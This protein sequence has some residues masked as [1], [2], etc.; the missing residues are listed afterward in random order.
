M[1]PELKP[2]SGHTHSLAK[3]RRYFEGKEGERVLAKDFLNLC[4]V[5]ARG[6]TWD[7]QMDELR[8]LSGNNTDS[9][10]G[11]QTMTY[12]HYIISPDSRDDVTLEQLRE[13]ATSWARRF[14]GDYQ[15]AIIYH[16]DNE[17]G[18]RHAHVIV[19]N[20][21]LTDGH[22]LSSDLTNR[23]VKLLNNALQT[24]ALERGLSAFAEDHSSMNEPEM[25]SSGKNVSRDGGDPMWRAHS[26]PGRSRSVASMPR[27]SRDRRERRRDKSQRG[28]DERGGRSWKGEICDCVDVARRLSANQDDFR[29]VLSAMG[30]RLSLSKS[31]D[32]LYTHPMGGGKSVRGSRLGAVYSRRSVE[33]GFSMNYARWLQRA[34]TGGASP[35][36]RL[37]EAQTELIAMS[38]SVVG[39]ARRGR[40]SAKDVCG[41]LDYNARFRISSYAGYGRDGEARRMLALAREIGVFDDST[42]RRA[43]RVGDDV[44]LVGKWIQEERTESGMGGGEYGAPVSPDRDPVKRDGREDGAASGGRER[45]AAGRQ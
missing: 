36:P 35:V 21:N 44:R 20:T 11:K 7:R 24:M 19:N 38:V 9:Y 6:L 16:D 13:L 45:A 4:D 33:A 2:I 12:K 34:R 37:N 23:R 10:R 3:A 22:R 25:S 17:A 1:M 31:G 43:K 42:G 39:T 30:V 15:V 14:F 40:V 41:L 28:I 29:R 8:D 26:G 32:F 27:P 5:D 18:I